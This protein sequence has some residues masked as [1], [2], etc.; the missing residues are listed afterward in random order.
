MAGRP[1]GSVSKKTL[2]LEERLSKFKMDPIEG[3]YSCLEELEARVCSFDA[4]QIENL[5]VRAS[6]WIDL[7]GYIYP[8]RKSID[9]THQVHQNQH[10]VW[11]LRYGNDDPN[12]IIADPNPA[13]TQ[14]PAIEEKI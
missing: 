2:M 1:K 5:K 14:N 8:K 3:L 6:I 12:T 13:S 11:D 7:L 4:D 9:I 10:V